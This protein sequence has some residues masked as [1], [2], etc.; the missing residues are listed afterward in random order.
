MKTKRGF[1]TLACGGRDYYVMAKYLSLSLRRHTPQI[2]IAVITDSRAENFTR[3]FDYVIPMRHDFGD[4]F[5]QKLHI[6][7]YTPFDE[8]L[9]IDCDSL[10]VRDVSFVW[11]L[12]QDCDFA[13]IGTVLM[14]GVY[15]NVD[16][17]KLC[18]SLKI[19]WLGVMNGGIYFFRN[20][21]ICIN[22]VNRAICVYNKYEEF[23]FSF[24]GNGF[25]SEEPCYAI[26]ASE[27]GIK[28]LVD[29]GSLMRTP[30]GLDG[31]L[32]IDVL[33]GTCNFIKY[34]E[35][36]QPAILHFASP[37]RF[38]PTYTRECMKL[39]LS[40]APYPICKLQKLLPWCYYYSARAY[41]KFLSNF[42]SIL[43]SFAKLKSYLLL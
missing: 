16:V 40:K 5:A 13:Y 3:Y 31:R 22:V 27:H 10:V 21:D 26:A 2:D 7:E 19:P 39:Y 23:G 32:H 43:G 15:Y 28:P 30:F 18:D 35:L 25:R 14:S 38:H 20:T 4:A 37:W 12:L 6:L 11:S 24:L 36:V 9:F 1:I 42:P 41:E 17:T 8:T 29:N 34:G 33:N